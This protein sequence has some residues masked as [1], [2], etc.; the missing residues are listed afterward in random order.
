MGLGAV[1]DLAVNGAAPGSSTEADKPKKGDGLCWAG[2]DMLNCLKVPHICPHPDSGAGSPDTTYLGRS[3]RAVAAGSRGGR[4]CAYLAPACWS[5]H[6]LLVK[7]K[8]TNQTTL[9]LEENGGCLLLSCTLSPP[10][11]CLLIPVGS[12]TLNNTNLSDDVL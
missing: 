6:Y 8:K 3:W 2:G 7:R 9:I 10:S 12:A 11:E 1:L 4:Q 5:W